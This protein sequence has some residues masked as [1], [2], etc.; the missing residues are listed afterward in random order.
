MEISAGAD[1]VLARTDGHQ[2]YAWG[3][4]G[5]GQN[6]IG[7]T[8]DLTRPH[9]VHIPAEATVTGVHAGRYH[10]LAVVD[11]SLSAVLT[12]GRRVAHRRV[13]VPRARQRKDLS[14]DRQ[15][16]LFGRGSDAVGRS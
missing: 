16:H 13:T 9:R 2:A 8:E 1:S 5:F 12:G 11:R 4:G 7:T 15:V 6:G 3:H 14:H 10:S